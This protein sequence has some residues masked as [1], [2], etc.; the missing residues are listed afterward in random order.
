MPS[1]CVVELHDSPWALLAS[2]ALA[3]HNITPGATISGLILPSSVDPFEEKEGTLPSG[4]DPIEPVVEAPMVRTFLA[5]PGGV[6]VFAPSSPRSP[7][8]KRTKNRGLSTMKASA[9]RESV[10]YSPTKFSLP[11]ELV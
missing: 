8:E 2:S 1:E 5:E 7:E 3:E 10:L 9:E 11:H 4:S 6:T